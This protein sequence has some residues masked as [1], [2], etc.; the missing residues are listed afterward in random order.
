MD[1]VGRNG[2]NIS[3][4]RRLIIGIP[5][6]ILQVSFS[7]LDLLFFGEFI[8]LLARISNKNRQFVELQ[9]NTH[10]LE[11]DQVYLRKITLI[12]NSWLAKLGCRM[13]NSRQLG[14]GIANTIHFS[15]NLEPTDRNDMRWIY[16]ELAH[17]LQWKYRG[18]IYIPEAL[19]AQRYSGYNFG[20]KT[21]LYGNLKLR[22][23]NPEQQAE[24]F[25]EL[26]DS[27]IHTNL[28][29]DIQSGK[30]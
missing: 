15:R 25:M 29:R 5:W 27:K 14:L 13:N 17:T 24:I 10:L 9:I 28:I 3:N 20:D 19:I 21:V 2:F 4:Q 18:L 7:L 8:S 16:H 23:F 22:E 26:I 12:E 11:H 1:L 30:W 6:W